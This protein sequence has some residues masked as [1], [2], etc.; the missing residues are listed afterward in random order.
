MVTTF[1]KRLINIAANNLAHR[2]GKVHL[3]KK[4]TPGFAI[5]LCLGTGVPNRT[6][7][8]RSYYE[9]PTYFVTSAEL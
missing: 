4:I 2:S 1:R 7:L 8:N 9:S 3:P 5:V 6:K